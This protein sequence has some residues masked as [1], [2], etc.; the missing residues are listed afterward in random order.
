MR[1]SNAALAVEAEDAGKGT[2]N[3]DERL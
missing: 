2:G 3:Y 1:R